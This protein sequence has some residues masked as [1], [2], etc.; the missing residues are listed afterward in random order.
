MGL[1]KPVEDY[2]QSEAASLAQQLRDQLADYSQA[3]YTQD[4]P[5]VEDH[6][7]DELYR[8]LEQLEAAFP[9][10][11]TNDSPTQKVGGQ[12]LPGFTRSRMRFPCYRWGC[13]F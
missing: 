9:V 2:T 5:L 8:D 7:Y 1:A 6:V 12:V 10:I 4:A 13:L 11:V 3:Y